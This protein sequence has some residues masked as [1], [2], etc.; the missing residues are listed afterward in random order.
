[1]Q[2]PPRAWGAPPPGPRFFVGAWAVA[3]TYTS[4]YEGFGIPVIESIGVGT[5]CVVATGSCLEEAGGPHTPAVDP[6]A[7][8]ALAQ[9]LN[10]IID[11]TSADIALLRNYIKRFNATDFTHQIIETY[12]KAITQYG[13]RQ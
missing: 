13:Q 3:S 8:E 7:P 5:P 1:P 4:R 11:G 12:Q 9:A 6:D 2:P 10:G